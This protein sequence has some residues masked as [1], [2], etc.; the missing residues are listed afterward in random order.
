LLLQKRL[1]AGLSQ[2]ELAYLSGESPKQIG[3][4]ERG[5]VKLG[6]LRVLVIL[7]RAAGV[8]AKK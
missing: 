6:A 4:R 3:Q 2:E 5:E 8:K 7:E 1:D